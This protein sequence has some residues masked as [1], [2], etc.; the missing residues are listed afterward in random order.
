MHNNFSLQN[1][2]ILSENCEK[3]EDIDNI[4]RRTLNNLQAKFQVAVERIITH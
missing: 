2:K 4:H 3:R 1:E